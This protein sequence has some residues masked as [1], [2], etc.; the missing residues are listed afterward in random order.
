[1][2]PD[3][4]QVL[5]EWPFEPGK[6]NVRMIRGEDGEPH[7]QV[8]LDLG[9]LQ[10]RVEGRPD[11]HRPFGFDSL[12]EYHEHRLDDL[13]VQSREN[14][15]TVA[16]EQ[17]HETAGDDP[18]DDPDADAQGENAPDREGFSLSPE[19]CKALRDEAA[20]YYHR[21]V[22]MFVLG[23]YETVVRDTSRNLRLLD[24]CQI[25]AETAEDRAVLEAVRPYI[26]MMRARALASQSVKDK[27]PKAALLAIDE[28]LDAL[29]EHY[30]E[31]GEPEEFEDSTEV[32]ILR[33]LRD[34]LAPKLPVSQKAEL[35]QRLRDALAAENYELAAILRDELRL[36]PD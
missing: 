7:L 18:L 27:E 6:L 33:D 25:H 4:T 2:S 31:A 19:D 24:F 12:L 30:E 15:G 14:P 17:H 29:R 28:G 11:G 5:D 8:R 13:S 1:M 9:V 10:M 35:R 21:Y 20:Q 32:R 26:T 36:L 23:D 34:S 16:G 3:L 22:A